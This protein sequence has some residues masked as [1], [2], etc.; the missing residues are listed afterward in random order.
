MVDRCPCDS[1]PSCR[2]DLQTSLLSRQFARGFYNNYFNVHKYANHYMSEIPVYSSQIDG[3]I[4]IDITDT[5]K[6]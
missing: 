3:D 2:E 6:I 1:L 4:I 5:L